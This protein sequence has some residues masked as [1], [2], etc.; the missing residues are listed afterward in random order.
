MATLTGLVQYHSRHPEEGSTF[1][2]ALCLFFS[3][4]P[5]IAEEEDNKVVE[6]CQND[7]DRTRILIF[8]SPCV[9]IHTHIFS[10]GRFIFCH[11]HYAT[12]RDNFGE[13]KSSAQWN[14]EFH[15]KNT[16][17]FL[18][19][20]IEDSLPCLIADSST[21]FHFKSAIWVNSLWS[22][23]LFI[24]STKLPLPHGRF[25]HLFLQYQSP[26]VRHCGKIST[27]L[28]S[29]FWPNSPYC[30]IFTAAYDMSY[31][32]L[33]DISPLSPLLRLVHVLPVG[34]QL[35]QSQKSDDRR[36]LR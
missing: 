11:R 19:H 8:V 35:V 23:S 12:F 21:S 9:P 20:Q 25:R 30:V 33:S 10:I 31:L 17:R 6:R 26:R 28:L 2:I 1:V 13:E 27:T 22:L 7:T 36:G 24:S 5:K 16:Y 34:D 3:V 15:L 29:N 32:K 4:Y 18:S 14:S